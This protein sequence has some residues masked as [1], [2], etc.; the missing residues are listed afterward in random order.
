ME[1]TRERDELLR[2]MGLSSYAD[3]LKSDLWSW[4]R[5]QLKP[6]DCIACGTSTGLSWHHCDYSLPILVG[7]Y[8][9][10]E[11]VRV[12]NDCHRAI[13]SEGTTWFVL[14]VVNHRLNVLM[15][16]FREDALASRIN[17]PTECPPLLIDFE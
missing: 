8:S 2:Q 1:E 14:D 9:R 5:S 17:L 4:I 16:R 13:H 15:D 10:N 11:I 6:A 3:Y 12:C 7:N